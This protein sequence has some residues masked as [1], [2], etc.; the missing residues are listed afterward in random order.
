MLEPEWISWSPDSPG[1]PNCPVSPGTD[2][3]VRFRDGSDHSDD[4]PEVWA[5]FHDGDSDDIIAYRVW[6][7]AEPAKDEARE[8]L[9]EARD[10]LAEYACHGGEGVPC[11]RTPDQC[12]SECGKAA[13]NTLARIDD[14]LERN[15]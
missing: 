3:E 8:L 15:R 12:R 2:C 1:Y 14:Y 11:L 5:W 4:L 9:V 13:G 10:A 6:P 7:A